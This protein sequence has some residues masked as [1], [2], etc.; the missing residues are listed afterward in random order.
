V[1]QRLGAY[2]LAAGTAG[3]SLLALTPSSEAKVVYTPANLTIARHGRIYLDVNQDGLVDFVILELPGNLPFRTSQFLGVTGKADNQVNCVT[4]FCGSYPS[5]GVL[6]TGS[7]IESH[8]RRHGWINPANMAVEVFSKNGPPY[9]GEAWANV[10]GYLGLKFVIKGE[11]HFGWA[12]LEV[13]FNGGPRKDRT[14]V[15]TLTGFAYETVAGK[16]IAAGQTSGSDDAEDKSDA[17]YKPETDPAVPQ[18]GLS[19]SAALG[20]L[21]LGSDGIALW[22]P[23]SY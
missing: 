20:T 7:Q 15:T 18:E 4:S 6:Q 11:I 3:V 1:N 8:E 23:D 5:A 22:R 12:R 9:Y 19:R 2:A 16:S 13:S 10:G 17:S 21:A 14:W